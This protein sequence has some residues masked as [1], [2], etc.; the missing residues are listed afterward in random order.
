MGVVC[1]HAWNFRRK[2]VAGI[3]CLCFFSKYHANFSNNLTNINIYDTIFIMTFEQEPVT[4]KPNI[5]ELSDG[6]RQLLGFGEFILLVADWKCILRD[7]MI[8]LIFRSLCFSG[9]HKEKYRFS[10]IMINMKKW[11]PKQPN[12]KHCYIE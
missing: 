12:L 2:G 5:R 1:S 9:K 6:A 7:K 8:R 4:K 3:W 11:L 10:Q